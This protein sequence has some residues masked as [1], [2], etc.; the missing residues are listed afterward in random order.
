MV[1]RFA[2]PMR[3]EMFETFYIRYVEAC[4]ALAIKPL[5]ADELRAL[6]ATLLRREAAS[7]PYV[8]AIWCR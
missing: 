6:I 7:A 3:I 8:I 2:W 1:Y 4:A 5:T